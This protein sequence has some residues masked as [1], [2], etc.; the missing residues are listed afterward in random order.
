MADTKISALTA[1]TAMADANEFAINE[2]GT[3]KKLTGTLIN[4]WIGDVLSNQSTATQNITAGVSAYL[5]G[6]NISVPVGKLRV[7]TIFKWRL[8]VVKTNAGT[9]AN[10]IILRVGTNGTT[11]DTAVLTFTTGTG[12]AAIDQAL[13]EVDVVCRGPLSA[14]GIFQGIM[15]LTHELAIT[16]FQ[17]KATRIHQLTSATFNVTTANLIV[18]LSCTTAASTVLDFQQ[19][20]AE[21]KGL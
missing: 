4:A 19:V 8:S 13:I 7:G 10:S 21:A 11:A 5:T 18:G 14:S 6:S 3:S 15:I 12:T 17:N 9:A 2:A 20:S 16:G 1:A